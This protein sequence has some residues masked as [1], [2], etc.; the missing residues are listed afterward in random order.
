[1]EHKLQLK[2]LG[3][4]EFTAESKELLRQ[5]ESRLAALDESKKKDKREITALQKDRAALQGRM[6]NTSALL[7]SIGGQLTKAEAKTL[8][9][10]KLY[11][12]GNQE[13]NRYLNAEKRVLNQVVENLWDKY[14]VSSKELETE[15]IKTAKALNGFLET[16]GYTG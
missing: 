13:L 11:D 9:L 2:R 16:L 5:V 3:S 6:A 15:R 4:D 14:A 10:K 12:L 7:A 1:L 8:I